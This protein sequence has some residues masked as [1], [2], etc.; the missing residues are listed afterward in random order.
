[1]FHISLTLSFS[2]PVSVCNPDKE[3]VKITVYNGLKLQGEVLVSTYIQKKRPFHKRSNVGASTILVLLFQVKCHHKKV[4]TGV[5]SIF[6]CQFHTAVVG[7][8]L[9][10]VYNKSELDDSFKDKRFGDDIR[11]E[12]LFESFDEYCAG[13]YMYTVCVCIYTCTLYVYVHVYKY[14]LAVA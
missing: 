3:R 14:L 5:E 9:R 2:L 12:L 4:H 7:E 6:R 13:M 11:V 10:L 1:M 8:N